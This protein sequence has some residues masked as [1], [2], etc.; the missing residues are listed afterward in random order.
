MAEDWQN[1]MNS[2]WLGEKMDGDMFMLMSDMGVFTL[3]LKGRPPATGVIPALYASD[4]IVGVWI[5]F[6]NDPLFPKENFALL[7]LG[8]KMPNP[9]VARLEKLAA[10]LLLL[11][12]ALL[13]SSGVPALL[14]R[15]ASMSAK[16]SWSKLGVSELLLLCGAAPGA[17]IWRALLLGCCWSCGV[18]EGGRGRRFLPSCT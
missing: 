1:E 7:L 15:K 6:P 11:P 9:G 17:P 18:E 10:W 8:E 3:K 5:S 14:R 16:R 12:P 2:C 4:V 13:N